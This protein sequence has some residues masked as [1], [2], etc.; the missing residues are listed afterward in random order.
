MNF[1]AFSHSIHS[2]PVSCLINS[3]IS[4]DAVQDELF[5]SLNI[6]NKIDNYFEPALEAA[7]LMNLLTAAIIGIASSRCQGH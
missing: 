6:A 5:N 7:P 1:N 2:P 3:S 4:H